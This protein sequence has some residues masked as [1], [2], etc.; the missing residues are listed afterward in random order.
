M[1]G[2]TDLLVLPSS[3][4]SS[5]LAPPTSLF[6]S[7]PPSRIPDNALLCLGS[8]LRLGLESDLDAADRL[9]GA[10]GLAGD[11]VDTVLLEDGVG[12]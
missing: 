1:D 3:S 10:T 6:F 5:L 2:R 12:E 8:S 9:L 7:F 4:S 11:K